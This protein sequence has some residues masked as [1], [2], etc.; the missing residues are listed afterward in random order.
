MSVE[1]WSITPPYTISGTGPYAISHP[2]VEGAIRAYVRLDTGLLALSGAEFAVSPVESDTT[3]NLTLSPTVATTYAGLPLIIDRVTPDEQGWLAVLG[4]REAGLAAQLDRM[5]QATQE[6]RAR[7]AGAL[8]IRGE[9]EAFDWTEGT[10]P[11][12]EGGKVKSGPTADAIAN[13]QLRAIEALNAA[14]AAAQSAAAA[15]AKENS[16]LAARGTW[17]TATSYKPSDIVRQGNAQYRC[18]VAHTSGV[19]AS[20]LGAARWEVW[21]QDGAPGPGTGDMRN[22]ENLSGLTNKPLAVTTLGF[23]AAGF[24]IG[25]ATA[26]TSHVAGSDAQGSGAIAAGVRL[27]FVSAVAALSGVTLPSTVTNEGGRDMQVVHDASSTADINVYPASGQGFEGKALNA[28]IR[29][30]PGWRLFL[31]QRFTSQWAYTL[32][33]RDLAGY[34]DPKGRNLLADK[35][36]SGSPAATLDFTEFNNAVYRYYFYIFEDV[37]P[38]TDAR[39]FQMLLSTNGGALFD[40]AAAS[41]GHSG[42]GASTPTPFAAANQSD[43]VINLSVANDVGNAANE[44]GIT[45]EAT[46]FHAAN[47]AKRTRVRGQISYETAAGNTQVWSFA[48][49]RLAAQDTDA[50]R[51]QFSSGSIAVGSRIR[52]YGLN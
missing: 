5:V 7:G 17:V 3:G 34:V 24:A 21:L 16:M 8:R 47:T 6:L 13:A 28:P 49:R 36:V 23:T 51:F 19:F 33:P 20:D 1:A 40:N 35:L 50:V 37:L 27:A 46:L 15:L 48:G 4:E 26:S 38:V 31:T 29:V 52:M 9:L 45:G 30:P 22:D 44:L 14:A 39:T 25:K 43:T 2:Y 12:L 32:L 11:I 18:L 42:I 10:V 41:Y